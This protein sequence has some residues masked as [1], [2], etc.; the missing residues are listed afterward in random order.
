[1]FIDGKS[2]GAT[3]LLNIKL[4]AGKHKL[5]F[6]NPDFKNSVKKTVTIKPHKKSRLIVE[7]NSN[8]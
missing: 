4:K 8:L 6:S 1:V 3:P 5:I 2:L 7:F